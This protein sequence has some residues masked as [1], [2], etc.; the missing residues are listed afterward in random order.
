M[1]DFWLRLASSFTRSKH[2][3]RK[4]LCSGEVKRL[5]V[6]V[7]SGRRERETYVWSVDANATSLLVGLGEDEGEGQALVVHLPL[8]HVVPVEPKH[9]RLQGRL[10]LG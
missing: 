5:E 1:H 9:L 7:H 3:K 10:F 4:T 6:S 2:S 8:I